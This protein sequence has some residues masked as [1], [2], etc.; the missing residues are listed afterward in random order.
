VGL[1]RRLFLQLAGLAAAGFVAARAQGGARVQPHDQTEREHA[2]SSDVVTLFLC[3]DVMT[4]RGIDQVLPHPSDPRLYEPHVT[5]ALRYVEL[6]ERAYGPIPKPVDFA[7]V[8]ADAL[9]ELERVRPAARI[10]NLETSVTKSDDYLAK[11]INYRMSPE[12]VGCITAAGIDCCA[13][14]NNHVLDWGYAGLGE[15]LEVLQEA[16]VQTAGAGRDIREAE[17]PA[18][19]DGLGQGRVIVFAFG[20]VTSGIPRGWA[21]AENR[22]GVNLL[23]D[24]SERTVRRIAGKVREVKRPHDI[25]VASIHWGANWGYEVPRRHAA[26]AHRLIDAAGVDVVHGHSSHHAKAIEVYRGKPILYGCG[27]FLNDYEGI[28][29]HEAYRDDL[30]LMYFVSIAR[31]EGRLVGLDMTPLRIRNFRL[32]RAS[33]DDA[34]WLRDTLTREGRR[35]GTR[36]ELKDD[37]TL[38]L[39]WG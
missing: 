30:A 33:R 14:A 39:G 36:A 31:P 28:A 29:G 22:P 5:S 32:N 37:N 27:D 17:A 3:G 2:A 25:V 10:V 1:G 8:W 4:G 26:F 12:N 20:S 38:A 6:A 35:F 18:V 19:L 34:R 11:G 23:G 7:Y 9:V 21:A 24:L 15:T 16:G 13:L